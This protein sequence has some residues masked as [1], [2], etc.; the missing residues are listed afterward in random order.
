M[1]WST[2]ADV[3]ELV[4]TAGGFLSSRPVEHS[5]LLTEVD[6]LRRHPEPAANQQYG[7]WIDAA[8]G[9]AG[10]FLQAP[11]H[12]PILTPLPD[13]A[14]DELVGVLAVDTGI[15]CDVTTVDAVVEAWERSGV[16]L[17]PRN[18]LVVHRLDRL[19]PPPP[20]PG[21]SRLAGEAD[22]QLLHRWFDELMAA[23]PGDPSDRSYVVDDP[24]AE[25]RIVLWEDEGGTPVAMAGHSRVV[26]GMTRVGAA[27][28]PAGDPG[29]ETAV[30]AAATA[31]AAA[32]AD[33]LLAFAATHDREASARWAALGYRAVRE[34]ILLVSG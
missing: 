8:G 12:P 14:V 5:P 7:W 9:V 1:P 13:D 3:E 18:R 28:V 11:R 10:A 22:A 19:R 31:E 20:R 2:T 23:N 4:A 6:H 34:R 30:L 24:L 25:G 29:T 33:D 27:Y 15:G 16:Q 21:R 32:V 26:D 17:V